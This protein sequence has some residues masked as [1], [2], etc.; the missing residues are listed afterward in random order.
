M[1]YAIKEISE[2]LAVSEY[3]HPRQLE[4]KGLPVVQAVS[5]VTEREGRE[6]PLDE[7][8][9]SY[10]EEVLARLPVPEVTASPLTVSE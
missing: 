1:V 10:V 7:V 6:V 4:D 5:V 3:G 8:I 2:R 9:P